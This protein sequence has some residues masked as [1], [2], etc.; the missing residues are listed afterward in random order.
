MLQLAPADLPRIEQVSIDPVVIAFA[1]GASLV[2]G[3]LFGLAPAWRAW[4][5]DLIGELRVAGGGSDGERRSRAR[6]VLVLAEA[7][8]VMVLVVGAGLLLRSLDNLLQIDPGFDVDG[9][10]SMKV[11][12]P[13]Y[14]L[15]ESADTAR[16]FD[17]LIESVRD[18]PGVASAGL[19]RPMPLS[20]D[21]FQGEDFRFTVEG[22]EPPPEGQEPEAV[23]RFASSDVFRALGV[24]LLAG[25]DFGPQDDRSAG[26]LRGIVNQSLAERHFPNESPI[27]RLLRAGS[28]QIEIIGV[29]A[30]IR[31]TGLVEETPNVIYAPLAQ[32]TRSGM[33]LVVRTDGSP[34]GRLAAI[35]EA[36]WK[37]NPDQPIE[38]IATLDTLVR[39]SVASQRYST[40]MVGTFAALALLLAAVGI[41]GVV[42]NTVAQR[43][44][45]IGIRMA[46]GAHGGDVVRWV[47]ARGLAW[48]AAGIGVGAL[49]A[50][51]LGQ[52]VASLLY[53]VGTVDPIV[54]ASA[55][56]VLL[57]V[58]LAASLLPARRAVAV[59]PV[60]SLRAD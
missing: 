54:Y 33:T 7:A 18:V 42:A 8:L 29:V 6:S 24:P 52:L 50:M 37:V 60:R 36:I 16:F 49:L 1:L 4:R 47:V 9:A 38:D 15:A 55:A 45:E 39:Q 11:A 3:L 40:W 27:G 22:Q 35:Q 23:L 48:V 10:I 57:M 30:D 46:L 21:T 2:T 56:A 53:D 51:A 20:P 19:V 17:D 32:V 14:R 31:Q 34:R 5:G 59:D 44:R 41:Y 25:R 26:V 12:A 43:G 13:G 28:G 58:A